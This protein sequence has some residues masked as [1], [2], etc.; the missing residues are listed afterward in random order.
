MSEYKICSRSISLLSSKD[1][2]GL[3]TIIKNKQRLMINKAV[4]LSLFCSLIGNSLPENPFEFLKKD[5]SISNDT[6]NVLIYS[7]AKTEEVN[8]TPKENEIDIEYINK[9]YTFLDKESLSID[10]FIKLLDSMTL[11]DGPFGRLYPNRESAIQALL[12]K[13]KSC[14]VKFLIIMA[15]DGYTYE[16]L[17]YMCAGIVGE[18]TGDGHCYDDAYAVAST[19]VNR[20][21]TLWYVN[22][23]GHNFYNIFTAPGQYEIKL[24]G[25]YLKF[26][27]RIDLEGYQA[28]VEALYT[29]ESMHPYLQFRGNWVK[30]DCHYETFA[31]RG[32]KF[33][34]K[35]KESDYVPYPEEKVELI[36][37]KTLV[38]ATRYFSNK[39]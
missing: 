5:N 6:S 29:R 23:Y 19:L 31:P 39:S 20:S 15:R 14:K 35:M 12:N 10:S 7:N 24:S 8:D 1:N 25:N 27:D 38:L 11:E 26:L 28:A 13:Y 3:S 37:V 22:N 2:E 16:E 34:D 18:A 36:Y 33:I 17:D 9:V 30:L 4:C 32:N 21:H